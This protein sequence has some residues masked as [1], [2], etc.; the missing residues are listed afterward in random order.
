MDDERLGFSYTGHPFVDVGL[1]VMTAFAGKANPRQLTALNLEDVAHFIEQNYTKAPLKGAY[2]MAFTAN[3]WFAQ[4][5]YDPERQGLTPEERASALAKRELWGGRHLRQWRTDGGITTERCVFTGLPAV[6]TVLSNLLPEG[7]A[8]RAQIPLLQGD[9]S[10]NFFTNG[11]SGIPISGVALLALQC[12]PL[13]CAKTGIGLLAVHS[14]DSDLTFRFANRFK[15]QNDK[16]VALAQSSGETKMAGTVRSLKTLLIATLLEIEDERR[17]QQKGEAP[18]SVTAYN[19]N[20]GKTPD[21]QLYHLPM[22]VIDFLRVANTSTYKATWSE[23]VRR[24]WQIITSGNTKG[25]QAETATRE[26]HHNFLYED[27][28]SLPDTAPRFIRTYFLRIPHRTKQEGDPRTTY[29]LQ[30][31]VTLVSWPLVELFLERIMGMEQKRIK[32]IQAFGDNLAIYTRTRGGTRFLRMMLIER[33]PNFLRGRL[34]KANLDTI[35][36]NDPELPELFSMYSY[37]DVFEE[38]EEVYRSDWLLARDLVLM[39]M[40]DQ[41]KGWLTQYPDAIEEIANPEDQDI[42]DNEDRSD[43]AK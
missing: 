24:G 7:R 20:N 19:F 39:R 9:D 41:L 36:A 38:G 37:I 17:L 23:I 14:E 43:T 5:A 15:I 6:T 27:L 29:S 31:E 34:I 35:R 22:Q 8:G 32:A 21:L 25:A 33:N 10:I 12:L 13:G 11:N 2:T 42:P 1:A 3:A 26:P 18:A 40:I 30:Q 16:D 4:F 28:F